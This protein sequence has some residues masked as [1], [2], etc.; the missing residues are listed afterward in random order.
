MGMVYMIGRSKVQCLLVAGCVIVLGWM[1]LA[2]DVEQEPKPR[3]IV[4]HDAGASH[5]V[6]S[7][8]QRFRNLARAL[9]SLLRSVDA[10]APAFYTNQSFSQEFG[11]ATRVEADYEGD[12]TADTALGPL[13]F[14]RVAI[15]YATQGG[16]L[17]LVQKGVEEK[18][19]T[20]VTADAEA[21]SAFWQTVRSSS[22]LT[23]S[24]VG[25]GEPYARISPTA[26]RPTATAEPTPTITPTLAPPSATP[27]PEP[28]PEPTATLDPTPTPEPTA[29]PAK[30]ALVWHREGQGA[31]DDLVIDTSGVVRYG[32]CGSRM[33]EADLGPEEVSRLNA[34]L[35][36]LAP[37]EY[38]QTYERLDN[39]VVDVRFEGE[40]DQEVSA[41]ER[42]V[43]LLWLT[44]L[45]S[46]LMHPEGTE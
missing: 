33:E 11:D 37:F 4:I 31:C 16:T 40:G 32:R 41:G 44:Q 45:H 10:Q 23:L 21:T 5:A 42:G 14:H 39:L 6:S 38:H 30:V 12:V 34:W 25:T 13:A 22:S 18:W 20:Y 46:R 24:A 36:D 15:V 3:L 28:P 35:A 17:I 7:V 27:T 1:L 2:C 43:V 8:D 26:T 9:G 19:A 29:T